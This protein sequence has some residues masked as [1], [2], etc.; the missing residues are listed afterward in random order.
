MPAGNGFTDDPNTLASGAGVRDGSLFYDSL[1]RPVRA[2]GPAL[3]S[4]DRLHTCTRYSN[5]GDVTEIWA[6]PTTDT[7][8]A[9]CNFSDPTLKRQAAYTYDDFGRKL[10][11]TD[12]LGRLWRWT[13]D[14][15]SNVSAATDAKSQTTSRMSAHDPGPMWFA[16]PSSQWNAPS[17]T[18]CPSAARSRSPTAPM[19]RPR[20]S[21]AAS[22]ASSGDV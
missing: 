18:P 16:T 10:T 13:Y 14:V 8:S 20:S 12:P 4:G 21:S 3:A 22:A 1:N 9:T 2:V 15:H 5:L 11:E 17:S 7:A 6:G 19:Q